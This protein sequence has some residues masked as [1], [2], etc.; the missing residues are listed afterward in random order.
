VVAATSSAPIGLDDKKG[1][2]P[3]APE[4]SEDIIRTAATADAVTRARDDEKNLSREAGAR[5]RRPR[6]DRRGDAGGL[7]ESTIGESP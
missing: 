2:R 5:R 1:L 3:E 6:R 4:A 7:V